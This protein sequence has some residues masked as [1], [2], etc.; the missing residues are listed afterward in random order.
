MEAPIHPIDRVLSQLNFERYFLRID[1]ITLAPVIIKNTDLILP[2][3]QKLL[4]E[5]Q[6]FTIFIFVNF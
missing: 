3:H 6:K 1:L 5:W 4:K 2:P